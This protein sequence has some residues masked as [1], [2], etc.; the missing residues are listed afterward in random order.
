M[1]RRRR[2]AVETAGLK[3]QFCG[4]EGVDRAD[5][6]V[7]AV[8]GRAVRAFLLKAD[9]VRIFV[10][11]QAADCEFLNVEPVGDQVV[12]VAVRVDGDDAVEVEILNRDAE[13]FVRIVRDEEAN[14]AVRI[15]PQVAC[16]G[17]EENFALI[18]ALLH[19]I[20]RGADLAVGD[21]DG[22]YILALRGRVVEE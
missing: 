16:A 21:V 14:E 5:K 4:V 20:L 1:L 7:A 11:R 17:A 22:E 2:Q 15:E 12:V 18:S 9:L 3:P 6:A 10:D 13:G 19:G 8:E